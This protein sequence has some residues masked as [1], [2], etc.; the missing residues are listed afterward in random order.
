M[1]SV[2]GGLRHCEYCGVALDTSC[3]EMELAMIGQ[4]S[5]NKL[6]THRL[7]QIPSFVKHCKLRRSRLP[8][9]TTCDFFFCFV[10]DFC[11]VAVA[12]S[13]VAL[14]YVPFVSSDQSATPFV[15][16]VLLLPLTEG[17]RAPAMLNDPHGERGLSVWILYISR[18][19]GYLG[20]FLL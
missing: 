9:T 12:A 1:S 15:P 2:T 20:L 10:S 17:G 8:I 5:G 6:P 7:R 13:S 14:A 18:R 3:R 16:C 11:Q 4:D 19:Q